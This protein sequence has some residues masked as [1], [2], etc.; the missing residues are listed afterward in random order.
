M[1]GRRAAVQLIAACARACLQLLPSSKIKTGVQS[2]TKLGC[3]ATACGCASSARG[4][5]CCSGL[6]PSTRVGARVARG[7]SGLPRPR[8]AGGGRVG[9]A[10]EA[11]LVEAERGRVAQAAAGRARGQLGRPRGAIEGQAV[12]EHHEGARPALLRVCRGRPTTFEPPE[13]P[14]TWVCAPHQ[15]V[16]VL[17]DAHGKVCQGASRYARPDAARCKHGQGPSRTGLASGFVVRGAVRASAACAR[18]RCHALQ[19][20]G[21]WAHMTALAATSSARQRRTCT[22]GRTGGRMRAPDSEEFK[23]AIM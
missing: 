5:A 16:T 7:G 13:P 22:G 2:G 8:C 17:R 23:T 3:S 14:R 21:V 4:A 18:A 12:G 1:R 15:A 19:L 10:P 11:V 20:T 6:A 9:R